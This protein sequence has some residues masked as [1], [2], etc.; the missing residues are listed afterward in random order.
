MKMS[1]ESKNNYLELLEDQRKF[2]ASLNNDPELDEEII[3]MQI[4]QIDMEEERVRLM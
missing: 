1:E 3:R 2:L 4:Y